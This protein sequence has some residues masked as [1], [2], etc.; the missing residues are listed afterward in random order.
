MATHLQVKGAALAEVTKLSGLTAFNVRALRETLR[1]Q[2]ESD[3]LK[4]GKT[5]AVFNMDAT[6]AYELISNTIA[7]TPGRS[8]PKASLYA[9]QRKLAAQLPKIGL[10]QQ[11]EAEEE[12]YQEEQ[13]TGFVEPEDT[14]GRE[15]DQAALFLCDMTYP[16][17]FEARGVA[18][19]T[20]SDTLDYCKVCGEQVPRGR[21]EAHHAGHKRDRST[22]NTE[23]I[24]ARKESTDMAKAKTPTPQEQGVPAVYLNED[25]S[26]FKPGSDASLKRDLIAA[27]DGLDNP[28]ALHTFDE[29]TAAKILAARGWN[30]WLIK[31]RKNRESKA[32]REKAKSEAKAAKT[33]AQVAA[34][35]TAAKAEAP[36]TSSDTTE[37][38]PDPKPERKARTGGRRKVGA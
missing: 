18:G 26:K 20:R 3:D 6:A 30:D 10:E 36:A 35:K 32:A 17:M 8:H 7:R 11:V 34:K 13:T 1:L 37:V 5:I 25:G 19:G 15:I 29:Q 31:S 12:A 23:R 22:M 9:V 33:K 4:L 16:N 28:K 21:Q 14:R 24:R 38:K 27:I 2:I